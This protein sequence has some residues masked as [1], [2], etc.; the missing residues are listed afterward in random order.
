MAT[1]QN[2]SSNVPQTEPLVPEVVEAINRLNDTLRAVEARLATPA[3][4]GTPAATAAD[5][6]T[7]DD[8]LKLLRAALA[9]D[10]TPITITD[11]TPAEGG[12]AGGEIV[13]IR[14]TNFVSGVAVFFGDNAATDVTVIDGARM[15]VK[16]PPAT[17]P[18]GFGT[19]DLVV[20]V[21]VEFGDAAVKPGGFSYRRRAH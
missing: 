13:T 6:A 12:S 5:I 16:T 8:V 9:F 21:A 17:P 15:T 19:G 7:A 14:G 20:D 10:T 3:A 4:A 1:Q 2:P 18:P 11:V